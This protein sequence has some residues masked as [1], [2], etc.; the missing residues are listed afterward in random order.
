MNASHCN[1]LRYVRLCMVSSLVLFLVLSNAVLKAAL[2][3]TRPASQLH[4]KI[5]FYRVCEVM[6]YMETVGASI[7]PSQDL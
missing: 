6:V 7:C 5:R 1:C 3:H 4:R 2:R